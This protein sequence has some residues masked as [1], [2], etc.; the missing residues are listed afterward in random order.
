VLFAIDVVQKYQYRV[1]IEF[2]FTEY[3][4]KWTYSS[5]FYY[6]FY[7]FVT[8]IFGGG[9]G[10]GGG[11]ILGPFFLHMNMHPTIMKITCNFVVMFS[12][13]AF[14]IQFALAGMLTSNYIIVLTIT[15]SISSI[16]ATVLVAKAV[17]NYGRPSIIVISVGLVFLISLVVVLTSIYSKINLAE[18][19]GIN[20]WDFG[21]PCQ[22]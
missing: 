6:A 4:I 10:F 9:F 13:L 14:S 21:S 2:P 22:I 5:I 8:G 7:G 11:T 12:S 19:E 20:I 16:I 1:E 18:K 17:K 15:A 3:D